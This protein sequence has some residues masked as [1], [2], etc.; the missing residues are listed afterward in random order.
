MFNNM[1]NLF[2]FAASAFALTLVSGV[3]G[4]SAQEVSAPQFVA[5]YAAIA[6]DARSTGMGGVGAATSGDVYSM[7][8]N[9]SKYS[10]AEKAFGVGVSYAP[11]MISETPGLNLVSLNAYYQ[12][13]PKAGTLALG[14]RYFTNGKIDKI[15]GGTNEGMIANPGEY[16]I[17][18]AYSYRIGDKFSVAVAG[19][20]LSIAGLDESYGVVR[21]SA[22]A[23]DVSGY[24]NDNKVLAN[25]KKMNWAVGL[26]FSNMGSRVAMV[27]GGNKDF[28]P[29]NVRLG[30][31]WGIE[32]CPKHGLSVAADF[33]KLLVPIATVT[34]GVSNIN[35]LTLGDGFNNWNDMIYAVG[36]EYNYNK[37]VMGR[38]GYSYQDEMAGGMQYV[39]LGVGG[40]YKGVALDASYWIP[41]TKDSP[42]K[43][44]F[45]L[46]LSYSF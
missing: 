12:I 40:Q 45:R 17:D 26:N 46:S 35:D 6:P 34:N 8:Y 37:M 24:Y 3:S 20:Y 13:G 5:G 25:G 23:G 22:F 32:M 14:A 15:V 4:V 43:N 28:L 21:K 7:Y 38:V 16:A 18:L 39:T 41:T 19:R 9:A 30:G 1:K 31:M 29:A 10:F 2:F 33:S 27:D 42:L 44:T 11:Q 36:V